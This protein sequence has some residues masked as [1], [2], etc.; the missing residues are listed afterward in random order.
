M[1]ENIKIDVT[2][3]LAF[4]HGPAFDEVSAELPNYKIIE[5]NLKLKNH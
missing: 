2:L 4:L 1:P 5:R 3:G